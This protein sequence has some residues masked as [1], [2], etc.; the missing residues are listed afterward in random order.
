MVEQELQADGAADRDAGVGER[1]TR[2]AALLLDVGDERQH[3]L[4][5]LG[6]RERL[7]RNG[8]VV[9]VA[10]EVPGEH[11]EVVGQVLGAVG[12]QRPGTGAEGRSEDQQRQLRA[13][14]GAGHPDAGDD[15]GHASTPAARASGASMK[16]SAAPR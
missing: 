2:I 5:Q 9:A 3:A 14:A 12:P 13:V 16:A 4:G 15:G 8:P 1:R 6:H 10:G 11:V 7:V